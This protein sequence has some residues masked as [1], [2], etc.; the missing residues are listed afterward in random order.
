MRNVW[1]QSIS[2]FAWALALSSS[3]RNQQQPQPQDVPPPLILLD[4]DGVINEDVGYPGVLRSSQLSLTPQAGSAIGRLKRAGCTVVMV[5][6]Q[7]SVGKGLLSE[8]GLDQIQQNLQTMLLEQD[9]DA[10]M[11]AIY[12]CLSADPKDPRRKPNPGMVLDALHDHFGHMMSTTTITSPHPTQKSIF[13]GDTSTDLQA[14]VTAGVPYRIL[15]STGYGRELM[16]RDDTARL[17][18]STIN[19]QEPRW[20]HTAQ[21]YPL[22]HPS[23]SSILCCR[24]LAQA[25]DYIIE[26]YL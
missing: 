20:I 19:E 22:L 14:A 10:H 1:R 13:V 6:N 15:V 25:A 2:S 16:Q 11:D 23:I 21:D 3:P 7:S 5:T 17:R 9:A 4:R 24:N 26:H 8:A 18:S 12:Q